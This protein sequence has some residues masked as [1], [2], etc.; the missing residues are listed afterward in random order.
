MKKLLAISSLLGVVLIIA[1]FFA[2]DFAL[3]RVRS[4]SMQPTFCTGDYVLV[5]RLRSGEQQPLRGQVVVFSVTPGTLV[6]KRVFG[7]GGDQVEFS[8]RYIQLN[9]AAPVPLEQCPAPAR[10]PDSVVTHRRLGVAAGYAFML[11]D[12]YGLAEDSRQYGAIPLSAVV[13]TVVTRIPT[14][15]STCPCGYH[16]GAAQ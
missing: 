7:V 6:T 4:A 9:S 8:S 14:T 15:F 11:G 12:N 2:G 5:R 1:I 13:G 3:L 16:L 10:L